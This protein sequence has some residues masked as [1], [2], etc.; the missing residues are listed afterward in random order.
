VQIL[1][2]NLKELATFKDRLEI[3]IVKK[4]L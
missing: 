1:F 4:N 3:A 2:L